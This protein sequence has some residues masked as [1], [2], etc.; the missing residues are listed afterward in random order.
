MMNQAYKKYNGVAQFIAPDY[1][2]DLPWSNLGSHP[3]NLLHQGRCK[4]PG[5]KCKVVTFI[6]KNY[7]AVYP[8][9]TGSTAPDI[10]E[11]SSDAKKRI[12]WAISSG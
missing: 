11:A 5:G 7:F 10:K 12:A 8:P 9:S 3:P 4:K 2:K 1:R 6:F